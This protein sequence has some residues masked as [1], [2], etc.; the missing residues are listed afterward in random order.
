[1]AKSLAT[2]RVLGGART[3]AIA[4]LAVVR[5]ASKGRD[6]RLARVTNI[7]RDATHSDI[8]LDDDAVS[9]E[10]VRVKLEGRRFVLYDLASLNGT[11]LNDERVHKQTLHDGDQIAVGHTTFVFKQ[12]E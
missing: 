3:A 10:H 12:V 7:G 2:T 1:M 4:W 11:L 5:G 6:Y 9:A 8:V